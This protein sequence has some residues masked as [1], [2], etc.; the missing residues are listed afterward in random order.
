MRW[1]RLIRW[2]FCRALICIGSACIVSGMNF[3][4]QE[5]MLKYIVTYSGYLLINQW[6]TVLAYDDCLI[7][8]FRPFK[9][10]CEGFKKLFCCWHFLFCFL[11]LWIKLESF[12]S[13]FFVFFLTIIVL[14]KHAILF[15]TLKFGSKVFL[16]EEVRKLFVWMFFDFFNLKKN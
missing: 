16:I 7:L 10:V 5:D 11:P 13:F 3:Y 6:S 14:I 1:S 8:V 4:R 15:P 12:K 9:A 2:C